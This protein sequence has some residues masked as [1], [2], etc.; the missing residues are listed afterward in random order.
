MAWTV[1][2]QLTNAS[3]LTL[4]STDRIWFNGVGGTFATNV[5]V[6]SYQDGTH[7]ADSSDVHRCTSSHPHNVKY[8]DAT[9]MSLD[10]TASALLSSLTTTNAPLIITFDTSDL[11]GASVVTTAA[12]VY[13]YSSADGT[14]SNGITI[15]G[16]E[17][18]QTSTW[19]SIGTTG[20]AGGGLSLADQSTALTHNFY[21]ALSMTPSST[22]AKTTNTLKLA[23]TYV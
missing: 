13:A 21:I 19:V 6:G 1:A 12:K 16:A 14:P 22:G 5:V 20:T 18:G 15:Q 2:A 10:G 3:R 8:I 7:V 4:A 17:A 23:L 9:H 11:G